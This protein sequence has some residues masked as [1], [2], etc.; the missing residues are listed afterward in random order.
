MELYWL[1]ISLL[2]SLSAIGCFRAVGALG[3]PQAV[4]EAGEQLLREA[5]LTSHEQEAL[6][7]RDLTEALRVQTFCM[8][9]EIGIL[10]Y[11]DPRYPELLRSIADPP[12]LLYYMGT[13]PDFNQELTIAV[14]GHRKASQYGVMMARKLGFELSKAGVVV[15]SGGA[16]GVDAAAMEGALRGGSPVVGVLGGGVNVIYP[17]KNRRLLED[18]RRFGCLLSEYPPDAKPLSWHFPVRNRII[19]GL[20]RGVVVAEA[21]KRSGSLITA[22]LALEQGRDVF[23]VPGNA[24]MPICAGSNDLLRQGAGCT[25]FGSDVI[26]SYTYLFQDQVRV[27]TEEE[28]TAYGAEITKLPD[29]GNEKIAAS[30]VQIPQSGDKKDVDKT[31]KRTYIDVQEALFGLS[32]AES[33]VLRNLGQTPMT[34]DELIR[35]T[36]LSTAQALGAL[37]MLEIRGLTQSCPGGSYTLAFKKDSEEP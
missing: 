1:W 34:A 20:S 2:E 21:P 28:A 19:S 6:R 36:G 18:V 32:E 13:L 10:T 26:Q 31:A 9:H 35:E 7:D 29:D 12:E 11:D 15:V 23:A 33:T 16:E 37:T 4:Y 27:L 14:V 8:E 25:E 24:G 3:S 30:E 22:R 5:G 17:K